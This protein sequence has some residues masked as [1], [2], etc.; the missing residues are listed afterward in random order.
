MLKN[1]KIWIV[2][3]VVILFVVGIVSTI[4]LINKFEEKD[5]SQKPTISQD[6]EKPYD[7]DGMDVVDDDNAQEESMKTPDS[8]EKD[9]T[10]SD[11]SDGNKN[12]TNS[13]DKKEDN[14]SDENVLK[15]D[16]SWGTIF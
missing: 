11:S 4:Q 1:K 3:V 5:D 16:T 6:D 10:S 2:L 15:D 13:S 9:S 14:K 7:G 12:Q 8:W